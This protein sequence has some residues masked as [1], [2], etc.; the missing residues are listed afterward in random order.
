MRAIILAGEGDEAEALY[1][2]YSEA[3]GAGW[4]DGYY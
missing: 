3:V 4:G 2:C 1:V